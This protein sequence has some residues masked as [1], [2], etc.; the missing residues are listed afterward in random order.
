M[1]QTT[2]KDAFSLMGKHPITLASYPVTFLPA[3]VNT[4][5]VFREEGHDFKP[6]I[7]NTTSYEKF[8]ANSFVS[9]ENGVEVRVS[10]HFMALLYGMKV[11]NA[12]IDFE[13]KN[14]VPIFEGKDASLVKRIRTDGLEEQSLDAAVLQVGN[15][16]PDEKLAIE[17]ND[18]DG[19]QIR[20]IVQYKN[21][22]GGH[23]HIRECNIT[24]EKYA[25]IVDSKP[26]FR[27]PKNAFRFLGGKNPVSG[28]LRAIA[29]KYYD[30]DVST[31][32]MK[33]SDYLETLS[34]WYLFSEDIGYQIG[35]INCIS[36]HTVVDKVG[37]FALVANSYEVPARFENVKGICNRSSHANDLKVLKGLVDNH[38]FVYRV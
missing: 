22:A 16:Q 12:I 23:K 18:Q 3:P 6:T 17:Y 11:T 2:F 25:E 26:L 28:L 24:P 10:E 33:N 36:D 14:T 8:G 15:P 1:K 7:H 30:L 21:L 29:S 20:T 13:E 19:L 27:V 4:G 31:K 5:I 38:R 35:A 32:A 37:A 9:R 34:Q